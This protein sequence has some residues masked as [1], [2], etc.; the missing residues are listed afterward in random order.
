MTPVRVGLVGYG[1]AGRTFHAPL[2]DAVDG[3]ALEA[4]VSSAGDRVARDRPATP[5]VALDDLA[6]DPGIEVAVVATPT[7]THAALAVRL[8]RAGKHVVVDKPLAT[9]E[10]EARHIGE[11]A[12]G[13]GLI[14]TTFHNR[15]WDADFLTLRSLVEDGAL[16]TIASVE[17]RFD[18]YRPV[19]QDRWRERAGPGSG[20]WRD[21]G[22][23][24]VD[25]ALAL[26]GLPQ[27]VSADL[28]SQR[29]GPAVDY[30]QVTLRY[31]TLRVRLGGSSLAVVP[32][33]RFVVLGTEAAYVKSGLDTQEQAL[34][35]GGRPGAPGWGHDPL[36]GVLT[37]AGDDPPHVVPNVP[38]DYRQFYVR[39]RDAIRG[40]G[41]SPVSLE[42]ASQ[43]VRILECAI[44]SSDQR[45]EVALMS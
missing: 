35:S 6:S 44:Q 8:L 36:P 10:Q 7:D 23:H 15:R 28:A 5:V 39:L 24:L 21:L 38:G 4:I 29:G 34:A 37:R 13:S 40:G 42:D 17:S 20:T 26:F 9:S 11:A 22:A 2:I 31:G 3:L 30:F 45:R 27:G 19:V 33:P 43:V 18:R 25:Q 12:R 32:G 14:A 16:G 1:Y 41:A